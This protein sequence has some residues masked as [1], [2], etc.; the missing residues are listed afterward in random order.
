MI[1]LIFLVICFAVLQGVAAVEAF[2]AFQA[3]DL[4][5]THYTTADGLP[6]NCVRDIVQDEEGFVWFGS[7]G[8]LVRFDGTSTKVFTPT[9]R[10]NTGDMYVLALCRYGR[11]LLVGTE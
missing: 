3:P 4:K 5:F 1:R 2:G 8:G 6:S 11:G 7:D 9:D 10:E